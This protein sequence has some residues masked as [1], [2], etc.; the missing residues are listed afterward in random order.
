MRTSRPSIVSSSTLSFFAT[1]NSLRRFAQI[2]GRSQRREQFEGLVHA[3]FHPPKA[4]D[5][6]RESNSGVVRDFLTELV[7]AKRRPPHAGQRRRAPV[8]MSVRRRLAPH[9]MDL[10]FVPWLFS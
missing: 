9:R 6:V 2:V 7:T 8:V 10:C 3:D 5:A 4:A 1:K